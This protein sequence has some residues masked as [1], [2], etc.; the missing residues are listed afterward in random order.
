MLRFEWKL[1]KINIVHKRISI[2]KVQNKSWLLKNSSW[3]LLLTTNIVIIWQSHLPVGKWTLI[4]QEFKMLLLNKL[5]KNCR[6]F[7]VEA[8]TVVAVLFEDCS[9]KRSCWCCQSVKHFCLCLYWIVAVGLD[10]TAISVASELRNCQRIKM[11]PKTLYGRFA[12]RR[13]GKVTYV[14]YLCFLCHLFHYVCWAVPL[15]GQL[16]VSDIFFWAV[17]QLQIKFVN[18]LWSVA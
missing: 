3:Q 12:P 9:W 17:D 4:W 8:F 14:F 1:W 5:S 7:E 11:T 10:G 6:W 16:L 2:V 13:I 18:S 15:H